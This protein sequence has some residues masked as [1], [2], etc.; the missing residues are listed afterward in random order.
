MGVHFKTGA[1]FAFTHIT[2]SR[3]FLRNQSGI[4]DNSHGLFKAL[5]RT[6]PLP[7]LPKFIPTKVRTLFTLRLNASPSHSSPSHSSPSQIYPRPNQ[8]NPNIHLQ[9]YK[10]DLGP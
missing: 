4:L 3:P 2:Y 9:K 8:L 1:L 7:S 5:T 10:T 6:V